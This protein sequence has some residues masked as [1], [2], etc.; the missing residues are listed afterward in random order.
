MTEDLITRH[1][2]L[3]PMNVALMVHVDHEGKP[4]GIK[5]SRKENPCRRKL[6]SID[7]ICPLRWYRNES[8]GP[9][10]SQHGHIT[11]VRWRNVSSTYM[12][13]DTLVSIKRKTFES[14]GFFLAM[15]CLLKSLC[16]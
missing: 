4:Y 15:A 8:L 13:M 7:V 1:T 2:S 10:L 6:L 9:F 12:C 5:A 14:K 3:A 16:F 11:N